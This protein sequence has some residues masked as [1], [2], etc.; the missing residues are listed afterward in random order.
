MFCMYFSVEAYATRE[1][2]RKDDLFEGGMDEVRRVASLLH[3]LY[4]D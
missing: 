2:K 3:S 1:N 4:S